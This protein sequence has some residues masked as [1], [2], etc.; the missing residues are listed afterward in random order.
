VLEN[1]NS[2]EGLFT[3]RYWGSLPCLVH[4]VIARNVRKFGAV[5]ALKLVRYSDLVFQKLGH[6]YFIINL[7]DKRMKAC[8]TVD[9]YFKDRIEEIKKLE[10][11]KVFYLVRALA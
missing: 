3:V 6:R 1:E 5:K 2:I 10:T 4:F 8:Q 7:N 9:R 11:G